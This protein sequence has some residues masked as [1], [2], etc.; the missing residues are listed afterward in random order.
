MHGVDSFQL[1]LVATH[2]APVETSVS[3][4]S[5]H[6]YFGPQNLPQLKV[7]NDDDGI[8]IPIICNFPAINVVRKT[9][10]YVFG[11]QIHIRRT[12][13]DVA[14]SFDKKCQKAGCFEHFHINVFLLYLCLDMSCMIASKPNG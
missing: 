3:V 9:G 1:S 2:V 6:F 7:N 13:D 11:V 12:Q 5:K 8:H 14:F 4:P 10:M